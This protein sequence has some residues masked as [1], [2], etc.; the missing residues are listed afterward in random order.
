MR[1]ARIALV[2]ML[3]LAVAP[4]TAAAQT[5]IEPSD[6][7]IGVT[8]FPDDPVGDAPSKAT[9]GIAFPVDLAGG[10]VMVEISGASG[11]I[12]VS[13]TIGP[14]GR[15]FIESPLFQYGPHQIE[16]VIVEIDNQ[17]IGVDR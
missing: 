9:L 6:I 13:G 1:Q 11:G 7:C 14:D 16:S 10:E 12:S 17:D 3:F 15:A 8:H 2:A 5:I 4:G